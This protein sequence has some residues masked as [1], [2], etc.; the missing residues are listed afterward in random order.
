MC[1]R[2][3]GLPVS[4]KEKTCS[5]IGFLA[6]EDLEGEGRDGVGLLPLQINYTVKIN[7]GELFLPNTISD[8]KTGVFS[9]FWTLETLS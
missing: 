6:P 7:D 2:F 9:V 4:C 8:R 1:A 5:W 3:V